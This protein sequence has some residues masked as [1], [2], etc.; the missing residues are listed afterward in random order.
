MKRKHLSAEQALQK[1][2]LNNG[3]TV[4][5]V[6]KEISLAIFAGMSNP[7]PN[8]QAMWKDIPH[9]GEFPTPEEM[10]TY[11]TERVIESKKQ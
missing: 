11:I 1:V 10:I 8:V 4:E 9:A 2:A 7:D 6:K 5:D 3:T